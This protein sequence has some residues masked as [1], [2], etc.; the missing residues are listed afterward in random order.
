MTK[1]NKKKEKGFALVLSLMMIVVMSIMAVTLMTVA[2][3]DHKKNETKDSR[4]Q[5]FYAAETGINE[6]KKW[7][8]SN[9]LLLKKSPIA[10]DGNA[11]FCKTTFFSNLASNSSSFQIDTKSLNDVITGGTNDEIE[12]LKKFSYEYFITYTPNESGSPTK[13]LKSVSNTE[14]SSIT[15]GTSYKSAGTKD[16]TYF[17]I[18]SCG[19][20]AAKEKCK[21]DNNIIVF[22]EA[23]VSM[24]L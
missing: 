20:N 6:A 22:L 17:T 7:M 2:G 13:V 23:V 16:A 1:I 21:S 9:P 12:R 5:V 24:V 11:R 10:R 4:Q 8:E 18:Y 19:C 3:N 15:E 14:G